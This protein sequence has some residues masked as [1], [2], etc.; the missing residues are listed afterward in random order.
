MVFFRSDLSAVKRDRTRRERL[1]CLWQVTSQDMLNKRSMKVLCS[2]GVIPWFV[3][4]QTCLYIRLA[5]VRG[6]DVPADHTSDKNPAAQPPAVRQQPLIRP[7][8]CL[9]PP[10]E[11]GGGGGIAL[12]SIEC[13]HRYAQGLPNGLSGF[14]VGQTPGELRYCSHCYVCGSI[15]RRP[16]ECMVHGEEPCPTVDIYGTWFTQALVRCWM[17]VSGGSLPDDLDIQC[18][19]LLADDQPELTAAEIVALHWNLINGE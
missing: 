13:F 12:C 15:I 2:L 11:G 7:T 18:M 16:A 14:Q 10:S 1:R 8:T 6:V 4:L 3:Y 9:V 17:K 19:H 5:I